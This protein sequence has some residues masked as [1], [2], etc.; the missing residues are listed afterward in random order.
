MRR[1]E[2][3]LAALVL[4]VAGLLTSCAVYL[5]RAVVVHGEALGFCMARQP[6]SSQQLGEYARSWSA[7]LVPMGIECQYAAEGASAVATV[8]FH[9][10]GTVPFVAGLGL[11]LAGAVGVAITRASRQAR[12]GEPDRE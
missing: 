11:A 5:F 1:E 12:S 7:P 9:D 3:R 8:D 10:F 2:L 4:L 6:D